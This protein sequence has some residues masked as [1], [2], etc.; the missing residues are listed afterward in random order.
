[1]KACYYS[2]FFSFIEHTYHWTVL[3]HMR[4]IAGGAGCGAAGERGEASAERGSFQHA[5]IQTEYM[6]ELVGLV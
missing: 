5:C 6:H 3:S 4:A 1:V 2:D